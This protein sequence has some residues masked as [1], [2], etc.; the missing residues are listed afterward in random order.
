LHPTVED[1]RGFARQHFRTTH[2]AQTQAIHERGTG[3]GIRR[4]VRNIGGEDGVVN[5]IEWPCKSTSHMDAYSARPPAPGR[6]PGHFF[7]D[8]YVPIQVCQTSVLEA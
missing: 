6:A 5:G 4:G 7:P 3:V 8:H 2:G 1:P